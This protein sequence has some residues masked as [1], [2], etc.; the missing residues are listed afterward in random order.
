[1]TRT[2]G[3]RGSVLVLGV[4]VVASCLLA[5]V[6]L[7]DA[8]AAFLQRQQLFALA[9]TAALAGAQA[10]DLP[11][12]YERGASSAT[13]LDPSA[14]SGRVRSHL[15]RSGAAQAFD[16][17][18][19]DEVRSDGLQVLVSLSS[20]LRLPFMSELF[21]GRVRVESRARLAYRDDG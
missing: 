9:D 21:P 19:L 14:V 18:V 5:V 12:Y 16:G 15:A 3:E 4:G 8:S 20:P 2:D 1:M 10:I 7:V 13:R 11:A 6:V 17:L